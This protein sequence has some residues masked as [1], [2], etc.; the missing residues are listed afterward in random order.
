MPGFFRKDVDLL[1]REEMI[2]YLN[3]HFR[4]FIGNT[5]NVAR[6]LANCV[7]VY[8][9]GLP[10]EQ[11]EAAYELLEDVGFHQDVAEIISEWLKSYG[12]PYEVFFNGR[13]CGYLVMTYDRHPIE[14]D[15]DQWLGLEDLQN[16]TRIYQDFDELCD[17]LRD[18][19]IQR[20]EEKNGR[21]EEAEDEVLFVT[22]AGLR[23][24]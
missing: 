10:S 6:S 3:E 24:V 11:R 20:L 4:Y 14:L 7:K 22:P 17:N 5:W 9:L 23:G 8:C 21:S 18:F 1:S 19:L 16:Y 12:D 15:L 13:S 2:K